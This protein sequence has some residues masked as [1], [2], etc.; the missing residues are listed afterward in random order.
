MRKA[1]VFLTAVALL[2]PFKAFALDAEWVFHGSARMLTQWTEVDEARTGT[3]FDDSD[4]TWRLQGNSRIGARVEAGDI[5]ARFEFGGWEDVKLRILYGQWDFGP[6]KFLVGQGYPP[7]TYM[8]SRQVYN[9]DWQMFPF[10]GVYS[11]RSSMIRFRF[12]DFPNTFDVA[13]LQPST[14]TR[15]LNAP[16]AFETDTTIPKIEVS[17]GHVFGPVWIDLGV[18]YNTFDVADD[19]DDEN[20]ID[21]YLLTLGLMSIFGPF[22]INGNA[23]VGQ[24]TGNYGMFVEGDAFAH[25]NTTKNRVE[26]TDSFGFLIIVRFDYSDMLT[27]ETGYGYAVHEPDFPSDA[28]EDDVS[29]YYL[30]AFITLAEG[31]FIVP[32]IGKIDYGDTSTGADGGDEV[33]GAIKWQINF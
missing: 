32:E 12:G 22:Y 13:F 14:R 26:D 5:D 30:H 6:G 11:G 3:G 29:A 33:Y 25:W 4:L 28:Q 8:V 23:Y 18:G 1:L 24:N 9:Q 31:V 2:V 21:S 27:F 10:G 17:W 20:S 19:R 15:G 7:L 16:F